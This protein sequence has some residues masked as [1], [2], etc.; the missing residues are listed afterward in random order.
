MSIMSSDQGHYWILILYI[1]KLLNHVEKAGCSVLRQG[2]E[3]GSQVSA[4][5]EHSW[6]GSYPC[7]P[8]EP[9]LGPEHRSEFAVKGLVC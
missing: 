9:N 5:R 6:I 7:V 1:C 4:E 2:G 3:C 8:L